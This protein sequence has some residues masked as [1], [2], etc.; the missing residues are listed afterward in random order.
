MVKESLSDQC[1]VAMRFANLDELSKQCGNAPV[2]AADVT[3]D[4]DVQQLYTEAQTHFGKIDF[5][6]H[7]TGG[8]VRKKYSEK[9]TL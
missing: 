6:V 9:N 4:E 5:I 8:S 1:P 2:V 7:S 3:K